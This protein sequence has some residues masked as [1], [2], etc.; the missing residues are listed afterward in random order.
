MVA[1]ITRKIN[2]IVAKHLAPAMKAAGFTKA[3][4]RF[5]KRF[6]E[7][8]WVV[9][10]QRDKYNVDETGSFTLNLGVYHPAW[11]AVTQ[12]T[13][14]GRRLLDGLTDEPGLAHCLTRENLDFL[15]G[16]PNDWW[17]IDV[18]VTSDAVGPAVVAALMDKGVTWLTAMSPLDVAVRA[19]SE[20]CVGL[21]GAWLYK[22]TAMFGWVALG[23][24]DEAAR[25]YK[26]ASGDV[27][28]DEEH[29]RAFSP[30]ARAR[31]IPIG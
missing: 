12:E 18:R 26:A 21:R 22:T 25:L 10:V 2:D 28:S 11:V 4:Q 16:R 31:G 27:I 5:R 6:D 13:E 29:E 17:K 7:Y 20:N 30:W 24:P 19:L 3:G 14:R 23:R 8:T 1:P 15:V 9:E